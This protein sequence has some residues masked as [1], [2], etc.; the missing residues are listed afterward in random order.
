MKRR[1]KFTTTIL[2]AIFLVSCTQ[3]QEITIKDAWARPGIAGGNSAVYFII[4]NP[5]GQDLSLISAS[6][7][8]STHVELHMSS[9]DGHGTAMMRP[10]ELVEIPAQNIVEFI[11]GGLHVMLIGLVNDLKRGDHFMVSLQF[12]DIGEIDIDVVVMDG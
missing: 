12:D 2:T 3:T 5:T 8:V 6:T 9:H 4:D 1:L 11:P 7:E 10:V